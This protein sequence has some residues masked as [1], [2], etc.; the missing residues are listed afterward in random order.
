MQMPLLEQGIAWLQNRYSYLII[1]QNL[2]IKLSLILLLQIFMNTKYNI[3]IKEQ[4]IKLEKSELT[5]LMCDNSKLIN[6]SNW[7]LENSLA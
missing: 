1:Y 3:E 4:G 6:N 2:S 7:K 5:R